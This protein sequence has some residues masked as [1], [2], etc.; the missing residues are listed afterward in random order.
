MSQSLI[1]RSSSLGTVLNINTGNKTVGVNG[2]LGI[3]TTTP[4]KILEIVS[5]T[6]GILFPILTTTQ[7]NNITTPLEGEVI[8]NTSSNKL[9]FY[10]AGSWRVVT[11]V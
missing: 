7:R 8:F 5:T 2:S 1:G 9:N 3:G 4:T 10:A 11:S 6:S